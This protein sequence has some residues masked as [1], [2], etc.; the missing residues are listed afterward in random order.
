[1]AWVEK[2]GGDWRRVTT[3]EVPFPQ[4]AD[5]LAGGQIDAAIF[6]EPFVAGAL[7]TH[8]DRL[9]RIGWPI[10]ETTPGGT[11]AQ[12]RGD[13]GGSGRQCPGSSTASPA[14]CTAGSTGSMR[15]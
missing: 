2:T 5:A 4:M 15:G 8:G 13:E 7:A 10:S 1:M 6:S 3:V 9:E 12:I 11:N 14:R